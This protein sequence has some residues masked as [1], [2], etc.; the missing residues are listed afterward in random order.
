VVATDGVWE[1][2]SPEKE[3]YGKDRLRDLLRRHASESAQSI[4]D[5]IIRELDEFRG[6]SRPLDD[7]TLIVLKRR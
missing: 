6:S 1:T 5:A 7:V 3:L 2:A 4:A